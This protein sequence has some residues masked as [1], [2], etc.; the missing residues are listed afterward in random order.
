MTEAWGKHASIAAVWRQAR[1]LSNANYWEL[2]A[3][4]ARHLSFRRAR[5]LQIVAHALLHHVG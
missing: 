4:K 5:S 2:R 3:A 1:V